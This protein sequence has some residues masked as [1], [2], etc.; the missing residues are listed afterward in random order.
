MPIGSGGVGAGSFAGADFAEPPL[1][2][3]LA[4]DER[5]DLFRL[6]N[7]NCQQFVAQ[8]HEKRVVRA[9]GVPFHSFRVTAVVAA[10]AGER[11]RDRCAPVGRGVGK[12][13]DAGRG[14]Q[15]RG[16]VNQ[17]QEIDDVFSPGQSPCQKT[18]GSFR[19]RTV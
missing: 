17:R 18:G 12:N 11:G 7:R 3:A 9:A 15:Q 16:A 6:R 2:A 13:V 5:D 1:V 10:Q 14:V 4:E 19:D 8:Q